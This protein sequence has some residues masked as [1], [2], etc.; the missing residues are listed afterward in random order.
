VLIG[1]VVRVS[2]AGLRA[3]AARWFRSA[4]QAQV[5][6]DHLSFAA[7]V[8]LLGSLVGALVHA[9]IVP[10]HWGD[11]R[12]TAIFILDTIGF[13]VAFWWAFTS[14]AHWRLVSCWGAQGCSMPPTSS[15]LGA[16]DLAGLVTTTIEAAASLVVLSPARW[17]ARSAPAARPCVVALFALPVALVSVLGTSEIEA[18][19]KTPGLKPGNGRA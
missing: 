7:R 5:R 3:L 13:G 17:P 12:M 8:A 2:L 10:T 9:A 19:L 16:M 15:G 1:P 4:D 6:L 14:R 18:A 11:E